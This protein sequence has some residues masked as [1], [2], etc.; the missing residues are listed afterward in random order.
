MAKPNP[1]AIALYLLT[2][3]SLSGAAACANAGAALI[4][5]PRMLKKANLSF[6]ISLFLSESLK[7]IQSARA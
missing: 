3:A 7:A 6:L 1:M 5:T 2:L 4:N